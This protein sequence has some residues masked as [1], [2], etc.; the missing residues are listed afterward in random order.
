M[1]RSLWS[2]ASGM[3]SQHPEEFREGLGGDAVAQNGIANC[4]G[5]AGELILKILTLP[6]Q[7]NNYLPGV[8]FPFCTSQDAFLFHTLEKRCHRVRFQEQTLGNVIHRLHVLLPQDQQYQILRIGQTLLREQG[9]IGLREK[10]RS[11]VQPE[12]ELIIQFKLFLNH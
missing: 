7:R 4:L 12:T 9:M 5:N 1:M 10:A 11:G 2:A 8:L 3:V 6:G